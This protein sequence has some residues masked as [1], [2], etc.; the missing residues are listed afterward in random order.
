MADLLV[1]AK[2]LR[3]PHRV[4]A[5]FPGGGAFRL[6]LPTSCLGSI[7]YWGNVGMSVLTMLDEEFSLEQ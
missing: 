3:N 4:C 6:R 1:I 2:H 7:Q 5:F